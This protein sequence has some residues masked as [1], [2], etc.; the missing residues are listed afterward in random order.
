MISLIDKTDCFC[1]Q[2][3][4]IHSS[5]VRG[6]TFLEKRCTKDV[7]QS[8]ISKDIYLRN[9]IPSPKEIFSS[10]LILDLHVYSNNYSFVSKLIKVLKSWHKNG[11]F[12]FF[13][14][15]ELLPPDADC[16]AI[17]LSILLKTNNINLKVVRSVVTTIANNTNEKNIIRVYFDTARPR[18][19]PIVCIN[20][21]YLAYL[22][23][24]ES[25][26]TSIKDEVESTRENFPTAY[27]A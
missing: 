24:M 15:T 5:F 1:N 2:C 7:Y 14:D 27:N 9:S 18:I 17:G 11:I 13:D 23:N 3:I 21:L 19:D 22:V 10:M 8:F 25:C 26:A 6:M 12:S 16:T 20:A 4:S